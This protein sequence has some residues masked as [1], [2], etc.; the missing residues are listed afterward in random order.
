MTNFPKLVRS[1]A[2]LGMRVEVWGWRNSFGRREFQRIAN[3]FED[4]R[5]T[6]H[7]LDE[8]KVEICYLMATAEERERV[9]AEGRRRRTNGLNGSAPPPPLPSPGN[10]PQVTTATIGAAVAGGGAGPIAE[11]APSVQEDDICIICMSSPREHVLIPCG[12]FLMCA[13]CCS[14]PNMFQNGCPLC[15]K[16][17]GSHVMLYR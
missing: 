13:A 14:V 6:I 1:A 17:V 2:T 3:L 12:H 11:P 7:L 9:T 5:V 10:L 15:R 8:Y 4:G 16:A